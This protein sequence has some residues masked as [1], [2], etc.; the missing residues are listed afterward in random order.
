[1]AN[2]S[3]DAECDACAGT[4]LYSGFAEP[5]GVAVVCLRCDGT[6]CAKVTY[7]PFSG[8]KARRGI[9][10]VRLSRGTTLMSGVGPTGKAEIS[11]AEFAA[12]A[13]PQERPSAKVHALKRKQR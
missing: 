12:G 4:G 13:M 6:G 7:K 3:I 2:I 1:M 11:Y 8:R 5:A 9:K 10:T